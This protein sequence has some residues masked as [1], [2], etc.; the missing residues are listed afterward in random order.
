MSDGTHSNRVG[1]RVLPAALALVV[2]SVATACGGREDRG[3]CV[4]RGNLNE[5]CS[6]SYSCESTLICN[7]SNICEKMLMAWSGSCGP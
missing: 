2:G 5:S 6:I 7:S 1:N 3:V 4:A